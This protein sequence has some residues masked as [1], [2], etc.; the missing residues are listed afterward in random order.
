MF[1]QIASALVWKADTFFTF[2]PEQA[3]L[4]SALGL[5]VS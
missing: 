5:R 1:L 3:K 2:D 4:A